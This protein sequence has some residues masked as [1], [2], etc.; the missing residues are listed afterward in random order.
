MVFPVKLVNEHVANDEYD[1]PEIIPAYREPWNGLVRVEGE[2]Q[3]YVTVPICKHC[4]GAGAFTGD[5]VPYGSTWVNLPDELCEE[6]YGTGFE[7]PAILNKEMD[8][9]NTEVDVALE[10]IKE[11]GG[12]TGTFYKKVNEQEK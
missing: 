3:E 12:D 1:E 4:S 2:D 6:C 8:K 11:L 9:L 10:Y 5:S 7:L